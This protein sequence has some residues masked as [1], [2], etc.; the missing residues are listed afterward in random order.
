MQ[1]MRPPTSCSSNCRSSLELLLGVSHTNFL[2]VEELLQL[3]EFLFLE[4]PMNLFRQESDEPAGLYASV[5]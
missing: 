3:G 4:Y 5:E 1:T 2:L